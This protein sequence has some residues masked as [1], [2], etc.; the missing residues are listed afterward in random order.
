M[1]GWS[2][3]RELVEITR[4]FERWAG[5]GTQRG[6][7]AGG[8]VGKWESEPAVHIVLLLLLL[9]RMGAWKFG[10]FANSHVLRL[11]LRTQPRSVA[12]G[13]E[14]FNRAAHA[15]ASLRRRLRASLRRQCGPIEFSRWQ[16][17]PGNAFDVVECSRA[18]E[19]FQ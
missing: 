19:D 2:D 1:S 17:R 16:V 4:L 11:V 13:Q 12:V 9:L 6:G 10:A 3:D 7:L 14:G 18:I 5:A 8:R 15:S